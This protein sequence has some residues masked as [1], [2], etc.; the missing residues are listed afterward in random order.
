MTVI[1]DLR[2]RRRH[3][4]CTPWQLIQLIGRMEQEADDRT[5]QML[6][7]ATEVDGWKT[8]HNQLQGQLDEAGIE[9]SGALEDLAAAGRELTQLRAALANAT[10]ISAPVGHRDIT[11][12]DRPTQP[13]PLWVAHGIGP[14]TAVADPGHTAA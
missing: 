4:G 8:A 11:P 2:T 7:L 12:G 10:A 6:V 9:L 13:I 14:V 1:Q 3:R 5:C